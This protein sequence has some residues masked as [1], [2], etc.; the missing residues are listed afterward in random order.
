MFASTDVTLG[1]KAH[2]DTVNTTAV[3]F[4]ALLQWLS[5]AVIHCRNEAYGA[6]K[7]PVAEP[8]GDR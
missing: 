6:G 2:G 3:C 1:A 4:H 8:L 7:G 5:Y